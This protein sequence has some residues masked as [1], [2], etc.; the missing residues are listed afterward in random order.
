M[1]YAV[2]KKVYMTF[3]Y[4]QFEKLYTVLVL[5]MITKFNHILSIQLQFIYFLLYYYEMNHTSKCLTLIIC[6]IV[7]RNKTQYT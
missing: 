3:K 4:I 7:L 1:K 2:K 6:I 5:E